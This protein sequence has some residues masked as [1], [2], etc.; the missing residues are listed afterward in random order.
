VVPVKYVQILVFVIC[1]GM[2]VLPVAAANENGKN[3]AAGS[4]PAVS[5]TILPQ[6][7]RGASGA[8][9]I[10]AGPVQEAAR[11][12]QQTEQEAG[13]DVRNWTGAGPGEPAGSMPP[14]QNLTRAR[15]AIRLERQQMNAT[16]QA[17][18]LPDQ[19]QNANR[20]EV[21]LAVHTLLALGNISGGI[22]PQVSVIAQEF[23]N[24]VQATWQYEERIQ[25]RNILSRLFFGGDE[26]A[27][28]GLNDLAVQNQNRIREIEQLMN[29]SD[30]EPET[31]LM[32]EEQ[33]RIMEQ[34]NTR[35][36]QV[37]QAEQ[38]DRGLFG[39]IGR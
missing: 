33:L 1:I 20:N 24:S 37:A 5:G 19:Q 18:N 10:P 7:T 38:A 8:A 36:E 35:L 9:E 22:G 2:L 6:G 17:A 4:G 34:E 26:A 14:G 39:W 32:L 31:R 28:T 12:E 13:S 21:R 29:A 27:A 16:L 25:N 11:Q 30:L 3:P 15:E 23:N